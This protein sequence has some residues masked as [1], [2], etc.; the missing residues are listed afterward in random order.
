MIASKC[1]EFI[2]SRKLKPDTLG[3]YGKL[4]WDGM[5]A[6]WPTSTTGRVMLDGELAATMR[7]MVR[8]GQWKDLGHIVI[9]FDMYWRARKAEKREL[10]SLAHAMQLA[11]RD[12]LTK[13]KAKFQKDA[14]GKAVRQDPTRQPSTPRVQQQ[15]R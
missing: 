9:D 14:N 11:D 8:Q 10:K 12:D 2:E 15:R 13:Q 5:T 3:F 6:L 1:A 4:Y 7:R